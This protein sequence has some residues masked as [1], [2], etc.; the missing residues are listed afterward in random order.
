[1]NEDNDTDTDSD[2]TVDYTANQVL[3]VPKVPANEQDAM[4]PKGKLSY[5]H[6]GIVRQSP[7][8]PPAKNLQCFY[9]E[10]ICHSKLE[11]NNHH[12][13]EHAKVKCPDCIR[14]FPTPDALQIHRYLHQ[15][16][17]HYKCALCEKVC[18]FKS[19]LDMHKM[20]HKN[21][22]VWYCPHG[23][24]NRDFKRKSDLTA[25]EVVH[26]GEDFICEFPKCGY[27]NKDPRLV[28]RHQRVHT[29]EAKVKC[30]EYPEKFVFYQQMKRHRQNIHQ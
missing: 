9:C 4:S 18:A 17:H 19:D 13:A 12:K 7:S 14:V 6:Y 29:K 25:H 5:K 22:K 10:V 1:M 30:P 26:S 21:E 8:S 15:E 11:L 28:K 3:K 20:K 23:G 27:S 2:K 24:C 16:S